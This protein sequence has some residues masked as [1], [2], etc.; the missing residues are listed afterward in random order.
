MA[1]PVYVKAV[2]AA[3]ASSGIAL[4]DRAARAAEECAAET[5]ARLR[6]AVDLAG[7]PEESVE[8]QLRRQRA[9]PTYVTPGL[10]VTAAGS[11][12]PFAQPGYPA[13]VQV[14]GPEDPRRHA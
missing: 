13:V 9:D 6:A 1:T 5:S 12:A 7:V 2:A 8:E 3:L 4:K 11:L 10:A 14:I